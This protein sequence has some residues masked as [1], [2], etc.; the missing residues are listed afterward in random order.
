MPREPSTTPIRVKVLT[1]IPLRFFQHQL[2]GD[3][4][5][6]GGCRF[7]FS[8]EDRDYDWLVV[9]D[10]LPAK[11]AEARRERREALA[12]PRSRTIL[13]TSEPSSI[14]HYGN[15]YT[16]QFGHV[17]T[18]QPSWALPHPGRV[19]SQAGLVWFYGV[20]AKPCFYGDGEKGA[21]SFDEMVAHPPMDKSADLA[22]VFSAKKQKLTLHHQRYR[23]MQYLISHVPE[24][25][26]YGQGFRRLEDK[27]EALDG[28]RYSIAVENYIGPHH[29]TEKLA[30]SFLGITLPFYAGCPNAAD[31]FPP[32]S[33]IPID[34][35]QPERAVG[36][37]RQAIA[38]QEFEKRLPAIL[39]ARR[40]VLYEHNFFALISRHVEAWN[41]LPVSGPSGQGQ[42][43]S[44]HA[45]R[46][47]RP[48]VG[49]EMVYGKGRAMLRHQFMRLK[50]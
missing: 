20:D 32:E 26:V 13:T 34:I 40:R 3:G 37:I 48:M 31:Y 19:H 50:G 6:W 42:I 14:K 39:E 21:M 23:F 16:R 2:P 9:Y 36:I 11:G 22:M 46:A 5:T 28:Y 45:L 25:A 10:D 15:A 33:F 44:R 43:L 4:W 35:H 47:A 7:S 29:W 41:A 12:C 8:P 24:M 27:S 30:D 1:T 17:I 18:S 49:V 38:D